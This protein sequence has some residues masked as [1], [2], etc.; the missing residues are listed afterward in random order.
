MRYVTLLN[1]PEPS[2][3]MLRSIETQHFRSK[4]IQTDAEKSGVGDADA[5]GKPHCKLH[6]TAIWHQR[7]VYM[8]IYGYVRTLRLYM[9]PMWI[10]PAGELI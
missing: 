4:H 9:L 3:G 6:S 1:S 7:M 5:D 8:L 2:I 10:G